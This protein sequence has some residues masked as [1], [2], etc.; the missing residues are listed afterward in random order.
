[1]IFFIKRRC[2]EYT[3]SL[4]EH[5]N[6]EKLNYKTPRQELPLPRSASVKAEGS[7]KAQ[8]AGSRSGGISDGSV[9]VAPGPPK[10]LPASQ[11]GCQNGY[12]ELHLPKQHWPHTAT[13]RAGG[14]RADLEP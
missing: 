13:R 5:R 10:Q 14:R 1:M 7:R 4:S 6:K 11:E 9:R 8:D 2:I 12:W 3:L